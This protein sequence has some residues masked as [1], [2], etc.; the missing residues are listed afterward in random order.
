MLVRVRNPLNIGA[1]ARAMANFGLPELVLVQPYGEAWKTARSARAGAAVLH[2][3]RVVA[4]LPEALEGC[5]S[6]I[7]TTA[8]TGRDPELA[9]E[10]WPQ[11]ASELGAAPVALVFGSE[12]TGLNVD[13]ISFCNRLARIPTTAA[14]PSMNLGQAVAVCA[15]ELLRCR[16]PPSPAPAVH[17]APIAAS[18]RERLLAAWL[19]LLE[20]LSA[21]RPGHRASQTRILRQML[22]RWRCNAADARR[23]LGLARQIRHHFEGRIPS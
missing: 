1:A 8:G 3:A 19:P 20:R 2:N 18:E 10:T 12:K 14:A 13:D 21:V 16:T 22:V 9:L 17:P 6:A 15:Y 5:L 11:V 23:L 7:A 4:S